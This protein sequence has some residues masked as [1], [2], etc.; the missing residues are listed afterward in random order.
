M[1]NN[2]QQVLFELFEEGKIQ[3][4]RDYFIAS[5]HCDKVEIGGHV[6]PGLGSG[7]FK[8]PSRAKQGL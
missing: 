1:S 2:E 6:F 8:R 7:K 5:Y 4:V 3:E